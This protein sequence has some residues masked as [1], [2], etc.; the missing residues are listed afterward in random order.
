MNVRINFIQYPNNRTLLSN[1]IDFDCFA[2]IDEVQRAD[3]GEIR[4]QVVNSDDKII[5]EKS[6]SLKILRDKGE[7]SWRK[8]ISHTKPLVGKNYDWRIIVN[9]TFRIYLRIRQ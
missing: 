1:C 3:E 7:P 9:N 2:M 8:I 6:I 5:E 4:C